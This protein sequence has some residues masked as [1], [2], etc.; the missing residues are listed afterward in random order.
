MLNYSYQG[1][2][3]PKTSNVGPLLIPSSRGGTILWCATARDR[4]SAI[5]EVA[6]TAQ[7]STDRCFIRGLKERL[8]IRTDTDQPWMWRRL[9]FSMK[10][11]GAELLDAGFPGTFTV[12]TTNGWSRAQDNIRN[13]AMENRVVTYLFRGSRNIDWTDFSAANVDTSRVTVHA[14]MRTVIRSGNSAGVYR[15]PKHWFPINKTLLYDADEVGSTENNAD[16]RN[17][18]ATRSKIG[19]GD[20]FVIDFFDCA[21]P[22]SSSNISFAAESTLYWHER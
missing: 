12:E 13:D 15:N 8:I 2:T 5:S 11:L 17:L 18:F 6:S 19:M 22:G 16:A 7:R 10:G 9:V 21:V 1:V 4:V 3:Y 20:L 14:D